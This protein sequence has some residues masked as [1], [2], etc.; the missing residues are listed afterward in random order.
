MQRPYCEYECLDCGHMQWYNRFGTP[1]AEKR[2]V[3]E[4]ERKCVT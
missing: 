4:E 1:V 3:P 2:T